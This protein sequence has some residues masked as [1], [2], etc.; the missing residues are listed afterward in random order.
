MHGMS[1]DEVNWMPI[2]AGFFN[3]TGRGESRVGMH[4]A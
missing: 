3:L 1:R 4:A 2:P